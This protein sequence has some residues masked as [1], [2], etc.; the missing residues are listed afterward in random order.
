MTDETKTGPFG[1]FTPH[2]ELDRKLKESA[3][4]TLTSDERREQKLSWV[5]GGLSQTDTRSRDEVRLSLVEQ[6]LL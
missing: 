4:L 3:G 2:P 5:M 1:Q 6:G